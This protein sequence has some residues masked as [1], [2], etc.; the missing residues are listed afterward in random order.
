MLCPNAHR[1]DGDEVTIRSPALV[2][3]NRVAP[4][5]HQSQRYEDSLRPCR[6]A[7]VVVWAIPESTF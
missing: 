6:D 5:S 7:D 4:Y 3:L 2:L 1:E